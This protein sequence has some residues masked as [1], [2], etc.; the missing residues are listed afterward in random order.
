MGYGIEDI[1]ILKDL[2]E[3]L[4]AKKECERLKKE[5]EALSKELRETQQKYITALRE[6]RKNKTK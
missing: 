2:I 3:M 4:Y 5:N 1:P 6:K